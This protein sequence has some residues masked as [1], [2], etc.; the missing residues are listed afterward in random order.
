MIGQKLILNS[1]L[2]QDDMTA[3]KLFTHGSQKAKDVREN[4]LKKIQTIT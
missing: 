2:L 3:L 4:E 1:H